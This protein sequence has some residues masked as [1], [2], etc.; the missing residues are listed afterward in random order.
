MSKPISDAVA[1]SLAECKRQTE[2]EGFTAERCRAS[3]S[4]TGVCRRLLRWP[5]LR[6]RIPSGER[7]AADRWP[8][9]AD[10]W[11][12][13]DHRRNLVK[14]GALILGRKS[15]A[16]MPQRIE[17]RYEMDEDITHKLRRKRAV[18]PRGE[19]YGTDLD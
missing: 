17:R 13:T 11:K 4:R 6:K 7:A 3:Q 9:S 12:P 19:D 14:A 5:R 2:V 8:W 10:W 16:L 15:N 18:G 1:M